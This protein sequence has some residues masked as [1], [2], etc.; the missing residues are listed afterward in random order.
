MAD[1]NR[2]SSAGF[3]LRKSQFTADT[4]IPST[5]TFDF[6]TQGMNIK[7]TFADLVNNLGVTG[8]IVSTTEAL[9]TPVLD[10]AGS[11]NTIRALKEGSGIGLD[12]TGENSIEIS[13]SFN[14]STSGAPIM[15]ETTDPTTV[16]SLVAGDGISLGLSAEEIQITATG[17]AP[18]TGKTVQINSM[19]DF[20]APVSG[21]ITLSDDTFYSIN[22]D[23][24]T[25]NRF[26]LGDQTKIGAVGSSIITFEYTGVATMFTSSDDSNT[27]EGMTID[28]VSGSFV[29]WVDTVANTNTFT[30]N[31]CTVNCDTLGTWDNGRFLFV[32]DSVFTCTTDGMTMTNSATSDNILFNTVSFIMTAGT[33][34]D[35]G[36]AVF[37]SIRLQTA[38]FFL[39]AGA[40]AIAGTTASGNVDAAG[41]LGRLDGLSF[42]GLGTFLTNISA[43]D[44]RWFFSGNFPIENTRSD[45]LVSMNT[46]AVETVIAVVNTPVKVAGL[47]TVELQSQFTA[48][49]DGRLTYTGVTPQNM[50]IAASIR[51]NQVGVGADDLAAYYAINGVVVASSE[52]ISVD[53][54]SN[55]HNIPVAWQHNFQPNDF[56]EIWVEN[57]SDTSNIV[58]DKAVF[59]VN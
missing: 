3:G 39:A 27:L 44:D 47:W 40:T 52:S 19:S 34:V 38:Q 55:E 46:N 21:V 48:T 6:V 53:A 43:S 1:S 45:G 14:V 28:C 30:V 33:A 11:V 12:I 25:S 32:E 10:K 15:D 9:T 8:T 29:D 36:T 4:T 54:A 41:G 35:L 13:T 37:A 20:P 42:F 23:L 56:V 16:R 24:T 5:A 49:T 18:V 7:V 50:P 31:D 26:V 59:R 22:N 57:Q 17:A 2:E 58:V 51:L